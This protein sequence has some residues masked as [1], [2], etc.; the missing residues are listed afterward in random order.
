MIEPVEAPKVALVVPADVDLA[1]RLV[2]F[3]DSGQQRQF[4]DLIGC[5]EGYLD[6]SPRLYTAA[7]EMRMW[8]DEVGLLVKHIEH[9]DRAIAVCRAIGYQVPD[10]GG[11]A[12]FTGGDSEDGEVTLG[13]PEP[14]ILEF[15]HAFGGETLPLMLGGEQVGEAIAVEVYCDPSAPLA[16][17]AEAIEAFEAA[18]ARAA[19]ERDDGA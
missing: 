14:L 5:R 9:N 8:V 15:I 16:A 6:R 1:I 2:E 10:V 17:I 13:L 7:G 18:E 3:T 11:T 19:A 4:E 12:I